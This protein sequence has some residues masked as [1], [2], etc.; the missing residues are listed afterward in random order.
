MKY[1][2]KTIEAKD[3]RE[4]IISEAKPSDAEE[5]L[6]YMD[7]VGAETDNLF[8]EEGTKSF[9]VEGE[10]GFLENNANDEESLMLVAK[11]GD[12]IVSL[13][14]IS[15]VTK[16][17]RGR[18]RA[19]FG[20]TVQKKAWGL[21]IGKAMILELSGFAKRIGVEIIELEVKT[22]NERAIGLYEHLGFEIMATH[23]NYFK[24]NGEYADAYIMQKYI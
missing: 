5:I 1:A 20:I 14:N 3:G 24:I 21:G 6:G 10:R 12:E 7:I 2:D 11:L 16:R 18:H 15:L 4:I 17:P 22:D 8:V 9:T 13:G 23:K 19:S